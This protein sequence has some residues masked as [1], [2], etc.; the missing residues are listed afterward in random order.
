MSG[1]PHRM[2]AEILESPLVL[3]RLDESFSVIKETRN[4][5]ENGKHIIITGSGTSFHA[6]LYGEFS[7]L[8]EAGIMSKAIQASE[9]ILWLQH[10]HDSIVIGVSQ[11]GESKDIIEVA[12]FAK[13][14]GFPIIA[15]TNNEKSS[16]ANMSKIVIPMRAGDEKA[17][18]A[19]KTYVAQLAIFYSLST[20][21]KPS[22]LREYAEESLSKNASCTPQIASRYYNCD[23]FFV[24][25]SGVNYPSALEAALKLK[26][27][28]E[29]HAEG[30]PIREFLHGPMEILRN[31][32]P[33]IIFR[34]GID[35]TLIKNATEK[36][37]RLSPVLHI[38]DFVIIPKNQLAFP[39]VDIFECQ[40]L[41]YYLAIRKGL[42][43]DQPE[44]LTKVV[45]E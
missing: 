14:R 23:D 26:E 38:P 8:T 43:P 25:G 35:Q 39:I 44:H 40:L 18:A 10:L 31:D 32:T 3:S 45:S 12:K 29:V 2:L 13:S 33:V 28:A 37:S 11:S 27:I 21:E 17:I 5:L 41:A 4:L 34:N 7:L 16:L 9:A 22:S 1:Y 6:A 30:F 19:T 42:E 20:G 24:L 36:L 15:I